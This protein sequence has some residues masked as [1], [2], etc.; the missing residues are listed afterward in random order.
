M[1]HTATRQKQEDLARLPET[2]K[3]DH[4]QGEYAATESNSQSLYAPRLAMMEMAA[5]A[6]QFAK[7]LHQ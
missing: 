4:A 7:T 2:A 6:Q 3:A 1:E 5:H